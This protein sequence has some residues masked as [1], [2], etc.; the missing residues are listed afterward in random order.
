MRRYLDDREPDGTSG[1]LALHLPIATNAGHDAVWS[2]EPCPT[3]Q[4]ARAVRVRV[5]RLGRMPPIAIVD[6]PLRRAF[7][8]QLDRWWRIMNTPVRYPFLCKYLVER[9]ADRVV[10]TFQQIEDL[11]G[12]ALPAPARTDP[13]WWTDATDPA[14]VGVWALARRAVKP[15]LVAGHVV[16]ER[17]A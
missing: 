9:Y 13:S 1:A 16:F 11:L 3:I 14:W 6:A 15:N 10:L 2:L 17:V 12:F 8:E 4:L 5:V 7:V